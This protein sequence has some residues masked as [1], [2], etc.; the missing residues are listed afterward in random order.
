[1]IVIIERIEWMFYN[2]PN[3]Y[4]KHN[5]LIKGIQLIT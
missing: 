3:S 5:F 4:E 1:M 2:T